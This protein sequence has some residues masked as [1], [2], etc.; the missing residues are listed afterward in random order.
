MGM[1]PAGGWTDIYLLGRVPCL[2]D[3][4]VL[5]RAEISSLLATCQRYLGREFTLKRIST[6]SRTLPLL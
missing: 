3:A 6:P 5:T 1:V 4:F 2:V